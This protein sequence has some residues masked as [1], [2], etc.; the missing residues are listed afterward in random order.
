LGAGFAE[1]AAGADVAISSVKGKE[2]GE[3]QTGGVGEGGG[4]SR[5]LTPPT[6]TPCTPRRNNEGAGCGHSEVSEAGRASAAGCATVAEQRRGVGRNPASRPPGVD[7][8]DG[9]DAASRGT[10][11][12][13][14]PPGFLPAAAAEEEEEKEVPGP[15]AD[16]CALDAATWARFALSQVWF[17]GKGLFKG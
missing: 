11:D 12:S 4:R 3:G 14:S 2:S 8:S 10:R 7:A 9:E 15:P 5:S 17:G 1:G 16:M 13:M 6:H